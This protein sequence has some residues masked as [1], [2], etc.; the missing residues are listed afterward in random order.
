MVENDYRE[1]RKEKSNEVLKILN[2]QLTVQKK[3]HFWVRFWS[4]LAIVALVIVVLFWGLM[5]A[6]FMLKF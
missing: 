1:V 6:G 3:I 4:V 5:V 2:E